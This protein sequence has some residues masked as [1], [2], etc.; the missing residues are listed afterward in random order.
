MP[1]WKSS[2]GFKTML[3]ELDVQEKTT[4][5]SLESARSMLVKEPRFL[6]VGKSIIDDPVMGR[7]CL[8][9]NYNIAMR[10]P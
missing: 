10:W 2:L 6:K 1:S 9:E 3:I 5:A 4:R 8:G 7:N